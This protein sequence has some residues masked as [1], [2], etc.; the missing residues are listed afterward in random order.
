MVEHPIDNTIVTW[1]E[2]CASMSLAKASRCRHL[3]AVVSERSETY[4]L[5]LG[6]GSMAAA[7]GRSVRL[8]EIEISRAEHGLLIAT[9]KALPG[10]LVVA[11]NEDELA[12]DIP[13]SIREMYRLQHGVEIDVLPIEPD[14][15][16]A[17][18]AFASWAAIVA[19]SEVE[20][21][22]AS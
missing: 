14:D 7:P 1:Y 2:T 22:R 20:N 13:L 11:K 8:I 15:G 3:Y 9:C 18:S 10:L 12:E 16:E 5:A 19:A 17:E 6:R 4:G 21:Y